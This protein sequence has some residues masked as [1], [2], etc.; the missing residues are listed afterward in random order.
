MTYQ[1]ALK[2]RSQYLRFEKSRYWKSSNLVFLELEL[3]FLV[4]FQVVPRSLHYLQE[5]KL[6]NCVAVNYFEKWAA[7]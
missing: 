4:Q 2:T 3:V 6:D 7:V 5:Q 1:I